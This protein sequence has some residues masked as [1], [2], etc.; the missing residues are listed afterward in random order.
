MVLSSGASS[1]SCVPV[2]DGHILKKS[3]EWAPIGGDYVSEHANEFLS[4]L[5]V[6]VVPRYLVK[7]KTSVDRQFPAVYQ[8]KKYPHVTQSYHDLQMQNAL[9]EF[10][11]SIANVA[12]APFDD[13][14]LKKR[15]HR[16]FEFANGY[17][18]TFGADRYRISESMFQ[19]SFQTVA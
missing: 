13:K 18:T 3:I 15:S 11:E 4:K 14:I 16:N 5:G 6:Q 8:L 17:N 7:S 2:L 10:K 1:T 19:E 9:H 12:E